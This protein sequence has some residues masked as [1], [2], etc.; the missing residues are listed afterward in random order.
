MVHMPEYGPLEGII[1]SKKECGI[2]SPLAW[3]SGSGPFQMSLGLG[4]GFLLKR[5]PSGKAIFPVSYFS[6]FGGILLKL[7]KNRLK[8]K[9]T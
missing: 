7:V 6:Y 3:Q 5:G 4:K 2:T 1:A 8:M 9:N